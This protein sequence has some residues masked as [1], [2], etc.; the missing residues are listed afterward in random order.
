MPSPFLEPFGKGDKML[1]TLRREFAQIAHQRGL[2]SEKV[3]VV[4]RPLTPEEAIGNPEERDYPLLK[5][6]ERLMQAM[7]KGTPGQA[8]TDMFGRY[9]G[10]I[11]DI[12]RGDLRTN[13]H[14]A[15]FISTLNAAMNHV[16]LIRRV[17]HCRDEEPRLC[18]L[19]LL[20]YIREKFGQPKLFLAGFQPRMVEV[21]SKA[22]PL[23]VTDLD[24]D[25][26]GKERFGIR[27]EGADRTRAKLSWCD[28]ALVT[29][30]TIV[31]DTIWEFFTRKPTV[32][33]GVT[34]SGAA[35]ILGL[36]HFCACSRPR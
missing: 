33:Y 25:N 28:V 10:T 22:F 23:K 14:R 8:F 35:K 19:E 24:P 15:A 3:Q 20:G 4:A 21:L 17:V 34:I 1:E 18:S 29:G 32:F 26:I 36:N 31:N 30:T 5:G 16:G 13:F 9:E 27:I 7:L 12:L 11:S 6:K 2:E